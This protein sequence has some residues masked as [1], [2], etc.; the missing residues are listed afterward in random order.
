[1]QAL[2]LPPSIEIALF[3]IVQEAMTNVV[4]HARAHNV[5]VRVEHWGD[6]VVLFIEDDGQGFDVAKVRRD[7]KHS[8]GLGL[9]SME[10]RA[11]LL[12]GT[13]VVQSSPGRGTT[14]VVEIPLPKD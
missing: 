1:L 14:L 2:R 8:M 5:N 11:T 9:L 3:R 4:K 13:L 12:G 6:A 10:E 7:R